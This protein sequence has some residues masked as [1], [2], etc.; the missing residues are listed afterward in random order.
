MGKAGNG[1]RVR[2]NTYM[3]RYRSP[4]LAL[5]VSLFLL[6]PQVTF[7]ATFEF[8]GPIVPESCNCPGGAA[9]WGC[10]L[11]LIDNLVQFAIYLGIIITVLM[12]AYAG[13][14]LVL[15]PINPENRSSAKKMLIN[16]AI[17]LV[18]VLASWLIV[19]TVLN[20]LG[21]GGI[22]NTT[23]V[24]GGDG[25]KC[26][27]P[28]NSSTGTGGGGVTATST[29]APSAGCPTCVSLTPEI[30][31]KNSSS[32]TVVPSLKDKLVSLKG[33][34]ANIT[35]IATEAYPPTYSHSN[36]CHK[37]GTCIDAGFRSPTTYTVDTVTTYMTSA[38]NAGLRPVFETDNCDLRNEVRDKGFADAYCKSD[39]GYSRITG[40]HFSLYGN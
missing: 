5:I 33:R 10:L 30:S 2:Y 27:T 32:C 8:L 19:N 18:L 25:D 24:L 22:A 29:P 9:G 6:A 12:A 31:C 23:S 40:T 28:N 35:W 37:N 20:I 21:A 14:L 16:A 39:S 7:G 13:F 34:A 26:L 11:D 1:D 4:I 15:N 38:K 3:S 36:P 17:G